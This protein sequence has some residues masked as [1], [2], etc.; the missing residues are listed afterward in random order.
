MKTLG[1]RQ[2]PDGSIV[3]DEGHDIP[4]YSSVC[5]FC[6]HWRGYQKPDDVR[7]TCDAFPDGIPLPIWTGENDHR[8][9][10]PGDHGI[11]FDLI[12]RGE[13]VAAGR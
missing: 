7:R 4:I 3:I 2:E 10:Y 8:Q 12:H 13:R 1:Y 6:R 11:Q 5:H 9:P